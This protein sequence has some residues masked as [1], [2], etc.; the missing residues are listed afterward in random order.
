MLSVL[1]YLDRAGS[2]P[3]AAWSL[4]LGWVKP[5]AFRRRLQEARA[6]RE[7]GGLRGVSQ[8]ERAWRVVRIGS[9]HLASVDFSRPLS[10]RLQARVSDTPNLVN[11]PGP[12]IIGAW[13]PFR[14]PL[15][16]G[17][18]EAVTDTDTTMARKWARPVRDSIGVYT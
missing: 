9:G 2:S 7:A 12:N 13:L 4:P 10:P 14:R 17:S 5:H 11:N 18:S 1:E 15:T 3:F 8:Y 6:Q 16:P